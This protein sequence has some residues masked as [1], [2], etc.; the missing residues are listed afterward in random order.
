MVQEN[1]DKMEQA[2]EQLKSAGVDL[3]A[4]EIAS[5][6]VRI[7]AAKEELT[8]EARE[9]AHGAST[10]VLE[11]NDKAN[12]WWVAHRNDI[13]QVLEIVALVYIIYRLVD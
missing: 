13:Y 11:A 7:D 10:A 5:L 2:L 3:F 6:Q 9:A 8:L 1:F 12:S 4:D